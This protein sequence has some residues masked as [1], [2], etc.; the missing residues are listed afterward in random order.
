VQYELIR[1][2]TATGVEALFIVLIICCND[3]DATDIAQN[4]H[5]CVEMGLAGFFCLRSDQRIVN[6]V[7]EGYELIDV[8]QRTV[9][10]AVTP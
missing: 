3:D 1:L 7:F 10:A 8:M 4:V 2:F 6:C 9:T 5:T